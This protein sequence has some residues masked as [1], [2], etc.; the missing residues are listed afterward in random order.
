[1]KYF[2][3]MRMLGNLSQ[4]I[5]TV[6]HFFNFFTKISSKEFSKTRYRAPPL[7]DTFSQIA[8]L[9]SPPNKRYFRYKDHFKKN[10]LYN[11]LNYNNDKRYRSPIFKLPIKTIQNF[12]FSENEFNKT[13]K[14]NNQNQLNQN[15]KNNSFN[16]NK[17]NEND[18]TTHNNIYENN[19]YNLLS[20]KNLENNKLLDINEKIIIIKN[21]ANHN[22]S[23]K[24]DEIL[25][26]DI[27]ENLIEKNDEKSN[28]DINNEFEI[29]KKKIEKYI[30]KCQD[31][32]KNNMKLKI[33]LNERKNK[34]FPKIKCINKSFSQEDL[35]KKTIEK[36]VESLTLIRPEI[37]N[38]IYRRKKNIFLK[39]DYVLFKKINS[40]NKNNYLHFRQNLNQS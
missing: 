15:R 18:E 37:K 13:K 30:K 36:K 31:K 19:R 35:F 10:S 7:L 21:K 2:N 25:N 33:F 20:L 34:I 27:K 23:E 5:V 32:K 6:P 4:N 12:F 26:K 38:S 16:P 29:E 8:R 22:N 9:N 1:M 24:K 14:N 39:K 40:Q 11:D 17:N 3:K 28:K